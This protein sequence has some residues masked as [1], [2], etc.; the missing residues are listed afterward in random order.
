MFFPETKNFFGDTI[1][2]RMEFNLFGAVGYRYQAPKGFL[3]GV[4]VYMIGGHSEY[5]PTINKR[6]NY[7]V[8]TIWPSVYLGYRIPSWNQHREF[9]EYGKLTRPE[10]KAYR[11]AEK[12]HMRDHL[13]EIGKKDS[14][15][16]WRNSEF[17]L[18]ILRPGL[19]ILHHTLYVPLNPRGVPN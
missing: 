18:S 7:P 13:A 1:A 16:T 14:T 9:V 19:V 17:G 2:A 10:R 4:N 11:R 12:Q 3:F 6:N 8:F 5:A 15:I